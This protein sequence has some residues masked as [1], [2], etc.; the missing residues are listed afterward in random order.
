MT[1]ADLSAG[2]SIF[3]D[4][5]ILVFYFAPHAVYG[6]ACDQLVQKIRNGV[7]DGFTSTAVLS[8]LA[9]RLMT[10]EA[11]TLFGWPTK[12]VDHLKRN[13]AAVGRLSLFRQVVA[14]VP[15]L[16]VRVLTIPERLVVA[17][18]AIS[19]QTGLL[20]NLP[21]QPLGVQRADF[22]GLVHAGLRDV[23]TFVV[24]TSAAAPD[25]PTP[26]T[27]ALQTHPGLLYTAFRGSPVPISCPLPDGCGS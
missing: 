14:K 6:P 8:E 21:S 13:P 9:H 26:L 5:N 10:F 25:N 12:V 1:F 18:A 27:P 4:A 7:L 16:G 20:S 17:T 22:V 2:E 15:R 23:D 3:L 19:Q 24:R 11:S